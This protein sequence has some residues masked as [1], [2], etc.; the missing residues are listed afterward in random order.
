MIDKPFDF[1]AHL[2]QRKAFLG[3]GKF[4][5]L[6]GTSPY[7][8]PGYAALPERDTHPSRAECGQANRKSRGTSVSE[9]K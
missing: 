3:A 7:F 4:L 5:T 2:V 9:L 6:E 8:R 1:P